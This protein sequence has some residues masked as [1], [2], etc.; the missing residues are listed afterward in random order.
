MHLLPEK[1]TRY[2]AAITEW[3]SK[4][5]HNLLETQKLYGKLLHAMLVIPAGQARLTSLEAMLGSFNNNPFLPHTPPCDTPD[6]L[7]WWKHQFNQP[8]L[9]RPIQEP[10]PL[11]NYEAY[12]D[13]SSGIGIRITV[14]SRW[15]AWQL[16]PGWKSQGRDIQ[17][18]EAVGFELLSICLCAILGE[19]EHL[20]IHGDNQG[21]VKGWW[22]GCSTNKPTN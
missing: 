20:L 15:W 12:S 13:A 2:L 10:Q 7:A 8:V 19:G 3:E 17:W 6:N 11:I 5:V 16:M 4:H 1:K 14:G 21:V 22:K 18:A 9:F